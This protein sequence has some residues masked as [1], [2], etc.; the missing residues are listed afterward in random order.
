MV[1]RSKV[2]KVAVLVALLA[3]AP[4]VRAQDVTAWKPPAPPAEASIDGK[5]RVITP[6]GVEPEVDDVVP[7]TDPDSSSLD[8]DALDVRLRLPTYRCVPREARRGDF[9]SQVAL[10]RLPV[11]SL[12]VRYEGI[13]GYIIKKVQSRLRNQWR[14]TLRDAYEE[15]GI[16]LDR[17]VSRVKHMNEVLTDFRAGGRWWERSW[18]D[19]FPPEKGGAPAVP[20]EEVIGRRLEVFRLGPLS[21]TNELRA[22]LDKTTILS[23]DPDGGQIYRDIEVAHLAREDARLERAD[24]PD[25]LPLLG[26][27]ESRP[28]GTEE[29]VV[30]LTLDPPTSKLLPSWWKIRF[31]PG[32]IVGVSK[33]FDPINM[34]REVSL[35]VSVELYLGAKAQTKFMEIQGNITYDPDDN[36]TS[37]SFQVELVTW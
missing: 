29:P 28:A 9:I 11:G 30:R 19:S 13:E 17:Y 32:M 4:I 15:G 5:G 23:F 25:E 8:F 7:E 1:A 31:R 18:L 16:D 12:V 35:D 14:T 34:L 2:S 20:Y 10:T 36:L 33:G 21:F 22:R 27:P 24:T 37:L 6:S 3:S 26:V